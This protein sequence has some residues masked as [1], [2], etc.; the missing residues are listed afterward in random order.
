MTPSI[1]H[2]SSFKTIET[3]V[4]IKDVSEARIQSPHSTITC[5]SNY[6]QEFIALF[7]EIF[8]FLHSN[9]F[10]QSLSSNYLLSIICNNEQFFFSLKSHRKFT[11]TNIPNIQIMEQMQCTKM[12]V[13]DENSSLAN[14][15]KI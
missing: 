5:E 15:L 12:T 3:I 4:W 14:F 10:S 2:F 7:Q 9:F 1:C 11:L 6:P 13:A 8:I